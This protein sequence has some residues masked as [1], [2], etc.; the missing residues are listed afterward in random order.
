[1]DKDEML[2]NKILNKSDLGAMF[3]KVF[4]K[5]SIRNLVA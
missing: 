1:M 4:V 5:L 2:A 3:L